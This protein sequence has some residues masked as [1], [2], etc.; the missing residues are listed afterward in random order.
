MGG[1][2]EGRRGFVIKALRKETRDWVMFG[3]GVDSGVGSG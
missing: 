3:I 1:G 2:V